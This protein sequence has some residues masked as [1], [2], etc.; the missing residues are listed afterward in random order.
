MG[1][2]V[3]PLR[4]E[5]SVWFGPGRV[6]GTWDKTQLWGFHPSVGAL[7]LVK[8]G[9]C[10]DGTHQKLSCC[11]KVGVVLLLNADGRRWGVGAR[12]SSTICSALGEG[13]R[14]ARAQVPLVPAGASLASSLLW[15]RWKHILGRLQRTTACCISPAWLQK[16]SGPQS[17]PAE[18][19][20]TVTS[21]KRHEKMILWGWGVVLSC[22]QYIYIYFFFFW[23]FAW[24]L[25]QGASGVGLVIE[26]CFTFIS[27][28]HM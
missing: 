5:W 16:T 23:G 19:F 4:K 2:G 17:Q 7:E 10:I 3:N 9:K 1:F 6:V 27:E 14:G 26:K 8:D 11:Y 21:I 22:K 24:K 13:S 20:S 15:P 18:T 28:L 12:S 25:K